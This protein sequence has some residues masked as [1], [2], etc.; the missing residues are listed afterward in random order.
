[1]LRKARGTF[2]V[3]VVAGILAASMAWLA[4][5]A[6]T[7]PAVAI[8]RRQLALLNEG[9]ARVLTSRELAGIRG[10]ATWPGA[11]RPWQ[12]DV[13]VLGGYGHLNPLSGNL[14]VA[15]P[16]LSIPGKGA[17]LSLTFYHNSAGQNL[18]FFPTAQPPIS[19]GWSHTY[20]V[21]LQGAGTTS[22]TVVEANGSSNTFSQN[23]NGSFN[24]PAG[25]W[26][27]LVQNGNGTYTLTRKSGLKLNF[28]TNDKLS[29]LV[30]RNGNTTTVAYNGAGHVSTVTDASSRQL[31]FSYNGS[32]QLTSVSDPASRS[33]T[34]TYSSQ[35]LQKITFPAPA[36]GVSQPYFQFG[37]QSGRATLASFRNRRGSTWTLNSG[38]GPSSDMQSPGTIT[39]PTSHT[40]V[41]SST[42]TMENGVAFSWTV[43][44]SG[45]LTTLTNGTTMTYPGANITHSY[46]WDSSRNLTTRTTPGG[47]DWEYTYDS[48]G[49]LLT[50]EDPLTAADGMVTL[51]TYT[52]NSLDLPTSKIDA[53]GHET[54]F[55]YDTNGN[56]T[57]VI[58]PLLGETTHT[59][60]TA[61]QRLTT[62]D[63]RG[64][65]CSYTYDTY[66]N[67]TET[68]DPLGNTTV[69][70][71]NT[72]GQ[73]TSETSPTGVEED[74][75][76]DNLARLKRVTHE[77]A[78]Y[79]ET[80]YD[81]EDAVVTVRDENGNVITNTYNS[82]GWPTAVTDELSHT[83]SFTYS[84]TGARTSLTNARGKTT[85]FTLDNA[86]RVVDTDY[87]DGTSEQLTYNADGAVATRVDGRGYTRS[88]A[89]DDAGR[90]TGITYP[91]GTNT[92]FDY[93]DNGL[94]S[95]MT[96]RTGTTQWTYSARDEMTQVNRP[97]G[98][99][100]Y[101]YAATG[102][103]ASLGRSGGGTT[104]YSLDDAGRLSSLTNGY[105]ETTSFARNAS[106]QITEQD[107]ANGTKSLCTYSG[108]RGW[109]TAIEHRQSNNTVLASYSYTRVY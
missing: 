29:S 15:I 48:R 109:L 12:H 53:L 38:G 41:Y 59:Y 107:N 74:F 10:S 79:V 55:D 90:L 67:Q 34:L 44:G 85:T 61:G 37:Y 36:I 65:V 50:V 105:S 54:D 42:V 23:M 63:A 99:I 69:T 62:T 5:P 40:V 1:M 66:G 95:E 96:D 19:P 93:L 73:R 46:T 86:G 104:Y 2:C 98:T 81:E 39:D 21:Y 24:A 8:R 11:P 102:Q 14:H 51:E 70:T 33:F 88:Y 47:H 6:Q 17:G 101:T 71:Y 45:N 87:P 83:T 68:E 72:L 3:R 26:D 84:P 28:G 97:Q 49:N 82:L 35:W 78:T 89:Y 60:D 31:T 56:L 52:Y 22:V 30:D 58:D 64:K 91:T 9:Q 106:G 43:D 75:T 77:D 103:I 20:H 80:S 4:G 7:A 94:R 76:Y 25:V 18:I 57:S 108:T 13:P 100:N 92:T 16:V 32:N 27:T